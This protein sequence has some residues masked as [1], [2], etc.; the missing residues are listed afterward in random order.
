MYP[1][2]FR[3]PVI[4]RDVPGYGVMLM[5]GFLLAI[6]WATRRAARSGANPE[7][8]LDCGFVALIAG[9]VGC[10]IMYVIHYWD[11]R[12]AVY[13]D[14]GQRFWAI[15]D[16]T[17]GGLEFYGGFILTIICTIAY[18]KFKAKVSL[19]WYLDIIAPSAALGLALGRVGCFLNGCCWGGT[20]DLPWGV[21]FP[22][23][24]PAAISQWNEKLPGAA[25][26]KELLYT[27][28]PGVTVP[29]SRESMA[30]TA[31]EIAQK[32]AKEA[33]LAK[34]VEQL[35]AASGGVKTEEL[36]K[37]ELKFARAKVD[38]LDIRANLKR[39]GLSVD[40]LHALADRHRALPVHPT[41]LY[42]TITALLIAL[43]LDA[44]YWRRSF[45]GQV[46]CVLLLIEPVTRWLIEVIRADNPID[47]MGV[48]TISQGLALSMAV[49][50]L[51]GLIALRNGPPRSRHAVVWEP[52]EEEP[53]K[54][55]GKA[56][57][58]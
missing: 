24:S 9:V 36:K 42:S 32:D 44:L 15:I 11:E 35:R 22:F 57:K 14:P 49:I 16:I 27:H 13:T 25:L 46:I 7:I 48:L 54:G 45:D 51:I 5:L 37:L 55:G 41:Q 19:R 38:A 10:R 21:E 50:A 12:F 31:E 1:I 3:L 47:T 23:G 17:K 40:E 52:P 33:E 53:K 4:G 8:I 56:A 30:L 2:V 20:C 29:I 18:L 28:K 26:P 6:W 43:L 34:Q 39:Y 58:A